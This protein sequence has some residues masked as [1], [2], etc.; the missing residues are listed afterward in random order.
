MSEKVK[1]PAVCLRPGC[2]R[3]LSR[4][5]TIL[6]MWCSLPC[7]GLVSAG[8]K[9]RRMCHDNGHGQSKLPFITEKA[10]L[11]GGDT[12]AEAYQCKIC[13]FWHIGH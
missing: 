5:V 11:Q 1:G 9:S 13:G 6:G 10:A 8:G 3:T 7:A 2:G 4:S 12:G